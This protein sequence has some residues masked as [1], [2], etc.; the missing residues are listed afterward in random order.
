M[1]WRRA[2]IGT[3]WGQCSVKVEEGRCRLLATA[4]PHSLSGHRAVDAQVRS[5]GDDPHPAVASSLNY[6]TEVLT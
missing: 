4:Q 2:R 5:P 3:G 6:T 1:H